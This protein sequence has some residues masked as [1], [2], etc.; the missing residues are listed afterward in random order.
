MSKN[1]YELRAEKKTLM[2]EREAVSQ[3]LKD[4]DQELFQL[5]K[6]IEDAVRGRG[7]TPADLRYAATTRCQC[8]AGMA[9]PKNMSNPIQGAW[10]CSA[11]LLQEGSQDQ[12]DDPLPFAFYEVKSEDQPSAGGRTT[13]PKS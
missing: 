2:A 7:L 6:K 10:T 4:L 11:V 1:E 3:R 8:G 9:Y 12:H 13:R 5:E